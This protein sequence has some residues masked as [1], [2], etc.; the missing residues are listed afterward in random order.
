MA[1]I[2]R[3]RQG[4]F[5]QAALQVV[6]E[7]GDELRAAEAIRRAEG[8]LT[9]TEF[10][11]SD[12]PNRPGVRR[13]EKLVRFST[14][15]AV[16]A[17]W[18]VKSKG[19]WTVT[20]AGREALQRYPDP[21]ELMREAFRLYKAWRD[22]QPDEEPSDVEEAAEGTGVTLEEAEE[23]A[24]RD[25]E[26]YLHRMNPYDFQEL[27]RALLQGMGYHVGW[28]S[29]PGPDK[30]IDVLAFTDP[31]GAKLPRIKVQVKRRIDRLGAPELRS[32]MA[33]LGE[34][35]VGIVIALGGF[36]SEA[37]AESRG[38]ERRRLTLIDA[39]RLFD[40]W[41]EHFENIELSDRQLL[42][43]RPVYYLDLPA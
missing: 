29:P 16:K 14:V 30:G 31:L 11:A 37:E 2:T 24:W 3:E 7:A 42:P 4:Q 23:S 41:V 27:V 17:G 21:G 26:D 36:T 28:V 15:P 19:A 35:D 6:L 40:L 38:Q 5:L 1:E 33:V 39:N 20:D 34:Q 10:E 25:I 32:F 12:Y 9:L 18:L 22:A 8:R 13:F 43:L